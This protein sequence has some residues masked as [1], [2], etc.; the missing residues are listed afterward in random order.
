MFWFH[1]FH[2]LSV[3]YSIGKVMKCI[4]FSEFQNQNDIALALYRCTHFLYRT[5]PIQNS[6]EFVADYFISSTCIGT[7]YIGPKLL[8]TVDRLSV[9]I[10]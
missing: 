8:Q 2:C 1:R 5:I 10:E 7:K 4:F 6:S 9:S 3:V